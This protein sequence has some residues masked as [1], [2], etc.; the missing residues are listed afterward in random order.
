VAQYILSRS[1]RESLTVQSISDGTYILPGDVI[2][3]LKEM[4]VLKRVV[5]VDRTAE[6]PVDVEEEEEEK[7]NCVAQQGG[8]SSSARMKW[9]MPMTTSPPPPSKTLV[10]NLAR[11]RRWVQ[12]NSSM[13]SFFFFSSFPSFQLLFCPPNRPIL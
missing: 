13:S 11:V 4:R 10:L 5:V 6:R 2:T 9:T 1:P 12:L 3:A 8:R 7:E